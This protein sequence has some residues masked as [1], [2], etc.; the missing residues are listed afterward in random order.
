MI[1]IF[2]FAHTPN[3]THTSILS[4][5]RGNQLTADALFDLSGLTEARLSGT[6]IN[7]PLAAAFPSLAAN[8]QQ[9]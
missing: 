8:M 6:P 2:L 7:G 5:I 4:D 3:H 9:L 1:R